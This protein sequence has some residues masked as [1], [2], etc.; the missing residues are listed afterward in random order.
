M[1]TEINIIDINNYG[2]LEEA[3]RIMMMS[4]ED[5]KNI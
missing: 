5:W 1:K 3:L 4:E 2:R